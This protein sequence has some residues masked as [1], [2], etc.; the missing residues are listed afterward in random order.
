MDNWTYFATYSASRGAT[1]QLPSSFSELFITASSHYEGY[2]VR[3]NLLVPRAIIPDVDTGT[4]LALVDYNNYTNGTFSVV[5]FPNQNQMQLVYVQ[6][7]V[8]RETYYYDV[9]YR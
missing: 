5:R 3:I 8:F 4:P 6:N 9:Y 1:R 7:N 2:G